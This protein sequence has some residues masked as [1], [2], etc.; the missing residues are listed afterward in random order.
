MLSKLRVFSKSRLAIILVG[1]I[2]IPFVFW[3]M[4]SV[5]S[6]GNTNSIAKIDNQNISTKDFIDHLNTLNLS[7]NIIK[8]NLDNNVLEE[9]LAQL[10]SQTIME[11]EIKDKEI[12]IT[13]KNLVQK[14]K[15]NKLF[16]ESEN[17]FSR[18]KY[19]KFLL[20]NNMSAVQFETKLRNR[21]LQKKLFNYIS[22]GIIIPNFM[23]DNKINNDLK[24]VY[25]NY[26][27]LNSLYKKEF[28]KEEIDQFILENEDELKMDIL[29]IK[30]AEINP[31]NLIQS[32]EFN[33]EFF[34]KIDQIENQ[35]LNKISIEEIGSNFNLKILEKKNFSRNE[36]T[37]DNFL[38]E[39]Y[40]K[41]NDQKIGLV[42]KNDFYI[43]YEIKNLN[44]VLPDIKNE[45]FIKKIK[46]NL[47]Y[48]EK[49]DYN[50][51]LLEKIQNKT[52]T[53]EEFNKLE[54]KS[55]S[56]NKIKIKSIKDNNTF[57][58]NSIK[59]IY[60]LPLNSFVLISDDKKNIFLSK[61]T[62][63]EN[64]YLDKSDDNF[65][66]FSK[67]IKSEIKNNLYTSYDYLINNKYKVTIFNSTLDRVKN[68]FR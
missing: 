33:K 66:N 47:I 48:K 51:S 14:L 55:G 64:G 43:L 18:M 36:D 45:K 35:I 29:N 15:N 30:Y 12:Y 8:Q 5:F 68:Y 65:L 61:I 27:S 25:L 21:E 2:I 26:I 24:N 22:G 59:L 62:K 19:E 10:I 57:D 38:N 13:E 4:G 17:N 7:Q 16:I 46:N 41:R 53:D 3:G 42:D 40:E 31:Q 39:I 44:R 67:N 6:S 50:I 23:L 32:S 11:L 52:F 28:S 56:A 58:I 37:K 60:S 20:E 34:Q 9:L 63:I 54:K 49:Y 1:I